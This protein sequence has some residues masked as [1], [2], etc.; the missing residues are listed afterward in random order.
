MSPEGWA[1]NFA[2]QKPDGPLAIKGIKLPEGLYTSVMDMLPYVESGMTAP[3]LEFLSPIK[4]PNLPQLCVQ[5]A[6][7]VKSPLD[8][9]KEYDNDVQKQAKQLGL[10]GW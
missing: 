1:I 5:T 7:G 2:A 10:A 4:G 6:L 8:N 9:A 3:A